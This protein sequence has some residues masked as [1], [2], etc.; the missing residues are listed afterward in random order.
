MSRFNARVLSRLGQSGSIFGM[1]L[2]EQKEKFPIKVVSADMSVVAG[3]DRFKKQF[4]EDFHNVG[5]AEQNLLGVSAGLSSEGYSTIAVAQACFIT[6][7]SFEQIRQY[8]GYMKN[9]VICVGINSGLSLTFFGNTHYAIEDISLMRNIQGLKIL[10]PADAISAV[11]LFENALQSNEPTYLRL[12]GGLNCPIVYNN[13]EFNP[14]KP[15]ILREGNDIVIFATGSMVNTALK[16]AEL[17]TD[18]SIRVVDIHTISPID[19][20]T[21]I[22]SKNAK[23]VVTLEEHSIN[24]GMGSCVA[25]I[26]SEYKDMPILLRLGM[27]D[28]FERIGDYQYLLQECRLT[29]ELIAEDILNKFQSL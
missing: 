23:L 7:R 26:F 12:H 20:E 8:L 4:P 21:I 27:K 1:S 5:I 24:G 3:L 16:V 17:I 19:R 9:N 14:E 6:M 28:F 11:M 29:P 13:I 22:N 18:I 2:I 15:N 10:S 25:E